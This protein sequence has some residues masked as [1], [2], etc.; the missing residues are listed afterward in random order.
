M[1]LLQMA[2]FLCLVSP[3]LFAV[4]QT[5]PKKLFGIAL[6]GI[7]NLGN[8]D[9]DAGNL[10]VKKFAGMNKFLGQGVHYYF[11]PQVESKFFEYVEKRKKPDDKYFKTSYRLYLLPVIPSSIK[12][13]EELEKTPLRMEVELIEWEN[14]AK[15]KD[16][17]YYWAIDLCKTIG[18]DIAIKPEINDFYKERHYDCIF[19]DD[20]R[21][22]K[23]SSSFSRSISLSFS[24][25]ISKQKEDAVENIMRK[26][27]VKAIKPY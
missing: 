12:T 4:E 10:P 17:A 27:Q 1:K 3:Q 7:Y 14:E 26:L 6:G 24:R 18:V 23:I 8:E 22:L 2:I 16:D 25:N 11:Q 9:G 13:V 5:V 19:S 21:K 15:T 20:G